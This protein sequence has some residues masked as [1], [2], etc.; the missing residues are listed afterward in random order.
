MTVRRTLS[1]LFVFFLLAV[2][3]DI[4]EERVG[5]PCV[6]SI[7]PDGS[8]DGNTYKSI[9]N[10]ILVYDFATGRKYYDGSVES[11]N[12][13]GGKPCKLKIPKSSVNIRGIFGVRAMKEDGPVLRIGK[14]LQADS[15]FV[16]SGYA[17]CLGETASDTLDLAKQWCSVRITFNQ[18]EN[19]KVSEC[20]LSGE[21]NGFDTSTLETARGSFYFEAE[22]TGGDSFIASVPRQGDNSLSLSVAYGGDEKQYRE[23]PVGKLIEEARFDWNKK[24]LDDVVILIDRAQIQVQI[25]IAD[26]EKGTDYGNVEI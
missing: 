16:Y 14:G 25:I 3:C 6:L 9:S 1:V 5:C 2:S 21:W 7:Y 15:V 13:A 20:T 10:D 26:W 19:W 17:D 11:D 23:F 22:A 12:F 24:D 4:K 18:N 8:I